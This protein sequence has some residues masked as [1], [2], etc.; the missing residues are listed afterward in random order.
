MDPLVLTE[1][2]CCLYYT[3]TIEDIYWIIKKAVCLENTKL[4]WNG[5]KKLC[6]GVYSHL[7]QKVNGFVNYNT[8]IQNPPLFISK[9]EQLVK[10]V[11]KI[12][13]SGTPI[14]V[15]Y[16]ILPNIN[17]ELYI[18]LLND[19]SVY[20][21][22]LNLGGIDGMFLPLY[23]CLVNSPKIAKL[24]FTETYNPKT[25]SNI[26]PNIV[27]SGNIQ[28]FKEQVKEWNVNIKKKEYCIPFYCNKLDISFDWL[29]TYIDS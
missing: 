23:A 18:R 3:N 22:T 28:W 24:Y 12:G 6:T 16:R 13:P 9:V 19:D 1:V 11:R 4:F 25:N 7:D 26:L 27:C 2:D 8:I 21:S 20:F 15:I 17:S 10:I 29:C 5:I 14:G